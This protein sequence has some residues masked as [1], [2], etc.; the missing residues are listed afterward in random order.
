MKQVIYVT[1][2][3]ML[4][5][6]SALAQDTDVIFNGSIGSTCTIVA[7][8]AGTLAVNGTN[9]VLASTEAG[10]AAA[11][12]TA[13]TTDSSFLVEV[14]T[15]VGFTTAPAG[16]DA[17]TTFATSYDASGAT[18]A[19]GVVGTTQTSLGLGVTTLSVNSSAT[20]SSGIYEAGTYQLTTTIRCST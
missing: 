5:V 10:G 1:T 12:A 8:S 2:G 3:G 14:L 17:N 6:G 7:D 20:K 18:T 11:G 19:S 13:T 4:L 16:S 15:P 9:T